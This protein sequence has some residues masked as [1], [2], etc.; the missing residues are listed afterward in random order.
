MAHCLKLLK[1]G[2]TLDS[3]PRR[4][5]SLIIDLI[6]FTISH[7]LL[8]DTDK[9]TGSVVITSFCQNHGDVESQGSEYFRGSYLMRRQAIALVGVDVVPV[10]RHGGGRRR[11]NHCVAAGFHCNMNIAVLYTSSRQ[12]NST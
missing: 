3:V 9:N 7:T 6:P 8:Q 10:G 12:P 2:M 11:S 1:P 5:P 4:H